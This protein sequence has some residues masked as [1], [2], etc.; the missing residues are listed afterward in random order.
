MGNQPVCKSQNDLKNTNPVLL[1]K[2]NATQAK[3]TIRT[4][5]RSGKKSGSS[6][7][8]QT[9]TTRDILHGLIV[10]CDKEDWDRTLS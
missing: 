1:G 6:H 7:D 10:K 2:S 5:D 3:E 9:T 8:F 4:C